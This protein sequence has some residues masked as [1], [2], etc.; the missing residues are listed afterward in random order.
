MGIECPQCGVH[1]AYIHAITATGEPAKNNSEIIAR[2]LSCGH[3]V[4]SK[5]YMKFRAQLAE[6]EADG[7][8]DIR[9]IHERVSEARLAVWA[10]ITA[11]RKEI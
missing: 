11:S 2:K 10:N 3:V 8:N 4:G 1:A 9:A 7:A 5:D 6:I